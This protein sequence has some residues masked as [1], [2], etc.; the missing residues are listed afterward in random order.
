MKTL[1]ARK[2]QKHIFI[3]ACAEPE[4][5]GMYLPAYIADITDSG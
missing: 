4:F 2:V 5:V 1:F 3:V